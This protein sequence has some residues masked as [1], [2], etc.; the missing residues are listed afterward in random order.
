MQL[1]APFPEVTE[2]IIAV[3]GQ[4]LKICIQCGTCT[5]LCP[6]NLVKEF[7]PRGMIR[8]AQFGL[9]GFESEALWNCVTCNTCVQKCPRGVEIIDV[10]RSM[11]AIMNETGTIPASLKGPMGSLASRGNPW[12]GERSDR[13]RW[14]E[15]LELRPY[16]EGTEY[17]FF[18][19]CTQ[20]YDPGNQK[21]ARAL[22]KVLQACGVDFGVIGEKESCCGDA[23]RK[24]GG[25]ELFSRLAQ[26][27]LALFEEKGVGKLL[28]ASPH[29]MN[30][31]RKDYRQIGGNLDAV[32]YSVLLANL[33]NQGKLQPKKD[34][35]LKVTYHDPC[36]LGRHNGIYE[37][38]RELIRAIPGVDLVEMRRNRDESLCC[39]GGGGGIWM[40][41]P[42]GER[43]SELRVAE[44][45]ETGAEVIVAACPYCI[46]MFEDAL[47]TTGR[48]ETMRVMELSELLLES[49][50][51]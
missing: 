12:G 32:H 50:E 3:A 16:G 8:L 49:L 20:A 47:K 40:E 41:V 35:H 1:L 48:S 26:A 36:Y 45:E 7:S 46:S 18:T 2:A 19:C 14:A 4:T 38:P 29:C 13:L 28:V 33:L 51:D 25:E 43:F 22:V 9:E 44:A 30:A 39:G 11:R 15:G 5:G 24:L 27:N 21:A 17:L 23:C 10:V 37:P 6:W 34:L 42:S 31:F